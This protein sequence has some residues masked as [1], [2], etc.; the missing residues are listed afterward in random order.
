MRKPKV[1]FLCYHNSARSQMAEGL[2]RN[3]AGDKFDVYSAGIEPSGVHP[4]AIKVMQEI[5][6]DISNHKSKSAGEF[7]KEHFGYIITVCDDAKEKCPT[8]P[9][10]AI[11]LHWPFEDP[12][13]VSGSEENRLNVFRKVRDQIKEK[14]VNWLNQMEK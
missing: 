14:I 5:G 11:R 10:I 1:L 4:L 7:L 9:G 8:F 12:A 6:I 2:L 3:L 13:S